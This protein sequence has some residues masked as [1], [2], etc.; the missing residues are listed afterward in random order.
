MD[1]TY[2]IAKSFIEAQQML[3]E[4]IS[5]FAEY[6]LV[7]SPGKI[8][9]MSENVV[10]GPQDSSVVSFGGK[11]VERVTELKVLWGKINSRGDESIAFQHRI[12]AAWATYGKWKHVLES[13]ACI[14]AKLSFWHATVG[15]SLIYNL[16]TCRPGRK[17]LEKL[18]IAQHNMVR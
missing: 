15:R 16:V 13:Q 5:E 9:M 11:E 10:V 8:K 7:L 2:I 1:D 12:S 3:D 18:A 17:N 14:R 6:G 4:L